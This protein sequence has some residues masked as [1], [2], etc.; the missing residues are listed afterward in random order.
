MSKLASEIIAVLHREPQTI[1][2]LME[3]LGRTFASLQSILVAM[4]K[5]GYV[6]NSNPGHHPV[7]YAA[8]EKSKEEIVIK[9]PS[10]SMK[11]RPMVMEQ[12]VISR[13]EVR[14]IP[15]SVFQLGGM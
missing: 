12:K 6:F 2:Q 1:Y 7:I 9:W 15:N 5:S 10:R 3:R 13:E 11:Q 4:R 14:K 8:T